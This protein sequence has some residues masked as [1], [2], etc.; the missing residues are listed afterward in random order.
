MLS[1]TGLLAL[2][3]LNCR[4]QR[5]TYASLEST[6]GYTGI[7]S[8]QPCHKKIYQSYLETGMGQSMYRPDGNNII[9]AFDETALVYDPFSD[10]YYRPFWVSGEM[11]IQEFRLGESDTV[12][13]RTEKIDYVV[14]SGHQTRSYLLERNGYFYEAPITWYVSKGIWDLSPGYDEGNNSRFER[15]IGEECLACHTGHI[16]YIPGSKNRYKKVSTGI[17]CEKCHGPGE[18]HIKA[19]EAGQLIDVGE[20]IDYTIVN[21]GKL[22]IQQQ[23]DVCQ[24]CHL[25]GI[26]VLPHDRSVMDFRPAMLLQANQDIF[27][28][29]DPDADAF[30]IASHAERLRQSECFLNSGGKLTCTT[31]HDPHK[32]ISVT[33][34]MVYIRQC[35]SC[36]QDATT[37]TLCN[38]P[39]SLQITMQGNC[40]SCHM[41]VGGTRDIPHVRFHDHKIR[42]VRKDQPVEGLAE[43][44]AFL[45]LICATRDTVPDDLWGKAWLLYYEQQQSNPKF[46]H[47][48]DS[49]LT[50]QQPYERAR[51][52]FYQ[53]K[54][55]E[56]RKWIT[57]AIEA[58]ADNAFLWF[59]KGEI[60]AKAN[61]YAEAHAA[62]STAYTLSPESVES[63]ML[64]GVNLLKAQQ[65]NPE[66]LATAKSL[67][68]QLLE[69]KPFDARLLTNLG[70]VYLNEGAPR[71]AESLL[72][73][74]L[75]YEPEY[76][77]A[78]ENLLLLHARQG[79][80]VLAKRYFERLNRIAPEI[81]ARYQQLM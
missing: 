38:A 2:F 26:N 76:P 29:Q 20:E 13:E 77:Q 11:F 27:L 48:A 39:D 43:T 78:L 68:E 69:R 5:E 62:F 75:K 74:A 3:V 30:G 41:P 49:L 63:G 22:P 79:N 71:R 57:Q 58:Q 46:L 45:E 4:Q 21:P 10:Y 67:F 6:N 24:Q 56:A 23:F 53:N 40:V 64:A 44:K 65:G 19:I 33:D 61:N 72:L 9:E 28:E 37:Q 80:A 52:A 59:L 17:D 73:Q 42:V 18:A 54:L 47:R 34:S 25:Q 7:Q 14:G 31:C 55:P 50:G 60:E 66:A 36:H 70:F 15:E 51:V 81:A 16:E 12:Y 8:C 1:V 32:S 35:E